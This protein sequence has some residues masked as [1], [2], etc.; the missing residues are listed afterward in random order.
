M[1]LVWAVNFECLD[2]DRNVRF[3]HADTHL[4]NVVVYGP[5]SGTGSNYSNHSKNLLIDQGNRVK[6]MVTHSSKK[7]Y[8][9]RS[10]VV[11]TF[12]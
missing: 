7:H 11:Y 8:V 6:V 9:S 10:R 5:G 12:D 2:L 4:E 3:V 1:C